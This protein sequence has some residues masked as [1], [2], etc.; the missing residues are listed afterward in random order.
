MLAAGYRR[1]LVVGGTRATHAALV[2]S[3]GSN[4]LEIRCV[5]GKQGSRSSFTVEADLDWADVLVIWA[6]TPL[7]HRVSRAYTSRATRRLPW[8]TVARR[9][10]EAMCD[11]LVRLSAL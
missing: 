11:E 5:D 1:L 10:V 3:L 7:P 4:D 8:I 2:D 6:T 9:G